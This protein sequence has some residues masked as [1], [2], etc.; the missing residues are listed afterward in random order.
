LNTTDLRNLVLL[1]NICLRKRKIVYL[2]KKR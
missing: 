1:S 2:Y